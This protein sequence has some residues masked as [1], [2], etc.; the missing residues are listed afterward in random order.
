[1]SLVGPDVAEILVGLL[2]DVGLKSTIPLAAGLGL[3]LLPG[4]AATKHARLAVACAAVPVLAIASVAWRGSDVALVGA[5]AWVGGLWLVGAVLGLVGLLRACWSVYRLPVDRIDEGLRFSRAVTVPITIGWL[6][7]QILV[8][9]AFPAWDPS[10]RSAA[11]AHERAHIARGDWAIHLATWV[12]HCALWFH[13]LM[14]VARRRLSTLAEQAAD[15]AVLT[16]GHDPATYAA[17]LLQLGRRAPAGSLGFGGSPLG[18]RIRA[19]LQD[20]PR[21]GASLLSTVL[22]IAALGGASV[23]A[24]PLSLWQPPPSSTLHCAPEAP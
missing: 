14:W 6:T 16:S 21:T 8:P 11:L 13:P 10:A 20:R 12:L 5:E 1:M 23:A 9:L 17:Q 4:S 19:I 18:G 24:A 2:V 3:S 22:V 15:D 7:P